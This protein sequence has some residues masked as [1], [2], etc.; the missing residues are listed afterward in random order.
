MKLVAYEE[1]NVDLGEVMNTI[2]IGWFLTQRAAH[3]DLLIRKT[4][5]E[6]NLRVAV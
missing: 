3:D 4:Q 6:I 1:I 5:F 2:G